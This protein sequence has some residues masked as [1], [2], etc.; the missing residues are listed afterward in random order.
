[1]GDGA[2]RTAPGPRGRAA[3]P[4]DVRVS[5]DTAPA[6]DERP[7]K[8]RAREL[9]YYDNA[10]RRPGDVFTVNGPVGRWME[11]VDA[12]TPE[13]TTGPQAAIDRQH[14]ELLAGMTATR[15]AGGAGGDVI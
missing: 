7:R 13:S 3:S 1:M 9:G 14:D 8:V 6:S 11:P 12:G 10:R 2:N 4:A 5:R 15:P